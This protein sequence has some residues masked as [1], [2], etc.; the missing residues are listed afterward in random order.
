MVR[1]LKPEADPASLAVLLICA[2]E[3]LRHY[4][5]IDP[6]S[7]RP[8]RLIELMQ[9]LVSEDHV[10]LAEEFKEQMAQKTPP[11]QPP[12]VTPQRRKRPTTK[13]AGNGRV[14]T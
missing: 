1:K 12:F 6:D 7:F 8:E 4:N 2:W 11:L 13:K 14:R 10:P 5:L 9:A 3:G